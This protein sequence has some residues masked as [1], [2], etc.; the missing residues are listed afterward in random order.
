MNKRKIDFQK[1]SEL[2][3]KVNL[4]DNNDEKK[5]QRK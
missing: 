5:Q 3:A 1:S 4:C 2:E